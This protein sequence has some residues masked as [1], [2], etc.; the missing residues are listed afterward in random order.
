MV[1]Y[2]RSK[3]TLPL[4]WTYIPWWDQQLVFAPCRYGNLATDCAPLQTQR[5]PFRLHGFNAQFFLYIHGSQEP[6]SSFREPSASLVCGY[7]ERTSNFSLSETSLPASIQCQFYLYRG[8][9]FLKFLWSISYWQSLSWSVVVGEY[10]GL[11]WETEGSPVSRH[12]SE[13]YSASCGFP[14]LDTSIL[15]KFTRKRNMGIYATRRH[16]LLCHFC[17]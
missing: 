10:P 4:F 17:V 13:Y 7:T 9:I 12:C 5:P 15:A 6:N 3:T 14:G 16:C 2:T 1:V 8:K 11:T